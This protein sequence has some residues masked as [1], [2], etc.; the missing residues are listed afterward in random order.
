MKTLFVGDTHFGHYNI[1]RHDGRPFKTSEE[2]DEY[3][4]KVWNERVSSDDEV[5]ILG[6]FSW[7]K[8]EK[9]DEILA[10][11]NGKKYL[12]KGNHDK[13]NRSN[14][15]NF[16]LVLGEKTTIRINGFKVI[17]NHVP[18]LFYVGDTRE[19]VVMLYA[20]IHNSLEDILCEKAK[21]FIMAEAKKLE[22]PM[23]MQAYNV[24]CMHF[25]YGPVTLEEIFEKYKK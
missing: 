5:Y 17:L 4:I 15:P 1:M 11:L 6:D 21:E 2:M 14:R 8:K 24:G 18:E 19:D 25:G 23:K 9:T 20:H 3:M 12:V 7:Y 10:R 13:F 22:Y 16:D